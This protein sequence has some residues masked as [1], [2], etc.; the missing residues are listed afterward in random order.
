MTKGALFS[1][2]TGWYDVPDL[3][4]AIVNDHAIDEEFDQLSALGKGKV[5]QGRL[6]ALAEGR[7]ASSQPCDFDLLLGLCL[8]LA[9]LLGQA[10]LCMHQLLVFALEL[11]L[12]DDLCQVD[13]QQACLLALQLSQSGPQS[14]SPILQSL[15]QPGTALTALQLMRD[16]CWLSQKATQILPDKVIQGLGGRIACGAA[17]TLDRTQ[18]IRMTAANIVAVPR[19]ES[20][21]WACQPALGTTDQSTQQVLMCII[22]AASHLLVPIQAG[23][24]AVEGV[25]ADQSRYPDGNPLFGRRGRVA[26]PGA[27]R[28]KS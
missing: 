13:L 25:L 6:K 9:K 22:V 27:N 23:L 18:D 12:L 5:V 26:E 16:Q 24:G 15:G 19:R 21:C 4:C 10:R 28:Q 2:G 8:E 3:D 14:A 11:V 20:P 17:L 7:D 1:F